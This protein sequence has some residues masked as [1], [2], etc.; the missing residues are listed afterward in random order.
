M[1]NWKSRTAG[2]L[3]ISG[4]IV[5]IVAGGIYLMGTF[6]F[7]EYLGTFGFFRGLSG[8]LIATGIIAIIGG[9]YAFRQKLWVLSLI[10]AIC[11]IFPVIPLG[12]VSIILVIWGKKEFSYAK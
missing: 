1:T 10:G 5:G 8:A 11:A 4:G 3:A 9:I 12:V 7:A 2:I 6:G